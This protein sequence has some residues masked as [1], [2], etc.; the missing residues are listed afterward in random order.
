[1]ATKHAGVLHAEHPRDMVAEDYLI[2]AR[3]VVAGCISDGPDNVFHVASHPRCEELEV[4]ALLE[5]R[6]E[7]LR[8]QFKADVAVT[9][10]HLFYLRLRNLHIEVL[11]SG[12]VRLSEL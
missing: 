5:R 4:V 10:L 2:V 9:V 1:M 3:L 6:E 8:H 12:V 11:S 7:V